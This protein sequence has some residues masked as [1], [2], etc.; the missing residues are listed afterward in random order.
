MVAN[1]IDTS[2]VLPSPPSS[3]AR[4]IAIISNRAARERNCRNSHRG[5]WKS[6]RLSPI[7]LLGV[8]ELNCTG[9][10]SFLFRPTCFNVLCGT[11]HLLKARSS[12]RS[13]SALLPVSEFALGP[14]ATLLQNP[15]NLAKVAS[16][17]SV[18]LPCQISYLSPPP[19]PR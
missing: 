14:S 5:R 1:C 19:H 10:E 3:N 4:L 9:S 2:S 8:Q 6:C 13:S 18:L 11:I 7:H 15:A 16:R 17:K 12:L